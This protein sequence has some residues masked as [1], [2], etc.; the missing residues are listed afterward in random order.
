MAEILCVYR[1]VEMLK[2]AAEAVEE[3]PGEAVA[4]V[5]YDEKPGPGDRHH[6]AGSPA[7][8]RPRRSAPRRR[9]SRRSP[10]SMRPSP[11]TTSTSATAR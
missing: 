10:A 9:I 2:A 8:A 11:A 1:K 3:A 5:S 7:E 6:G 4:I